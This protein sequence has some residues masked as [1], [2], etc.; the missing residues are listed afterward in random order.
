MSHIQLTKAPLIAMVRAY[1]TSR[2]I[3]IIAVR[4]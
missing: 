3:V 2:N 1:L 4:K